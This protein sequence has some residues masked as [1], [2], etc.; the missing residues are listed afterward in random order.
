MKPETSKK[1]DTLLLSDAGWKVGMAE[2]EPHPLGWAQSSAYVSFRD[3]SVNDAKEPVQEEAARLLRDKYEIGSAALVRSSSFNRQAPNGTMVL[4]VKQHDFDRLDALKVMALPNF[5]K[6]NEVTTGGQTQRAQNLRA[7]KLSSVQIDYI[8]KILRK[9]AVDSKVTDSASLA[10][11]GGGPIRVI[12]VTGQDNIAKL[13]D[14][15]PT[16]EPLRQPVQ[17]QPSSKPGRKSYQHLR[18]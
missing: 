5:W 1:I 18:S 6:E 10:Q 3:L 2:R 8:Q 9:N 16:L 11:K 4:R 14:A 7:D 17:V 15:I 12:R 13:A